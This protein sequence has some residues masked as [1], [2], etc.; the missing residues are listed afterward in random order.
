M[1][2]ARHAAVLLQRAS[3]SATLGS[4]ISKIVQLVVQAT[5]VFSLQTQHNSQYKPH[6]CTLL[7]QYHPHY[8]KPNQ[9]GL[10]DKVAKQQRTAYY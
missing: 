2:M 1:V 4:L 8:Y 9:I 5:F 7:S 3:H 10:R 6:A